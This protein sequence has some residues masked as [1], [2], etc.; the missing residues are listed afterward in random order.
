M[1]ISVTCHPYANRISAK[2]PVTCHPYLS[3]VLATYQPYVS[4]MPERLKILKT[5][6]NSITSIIIPS[7]DCNFVLVI[8]ILPKFS[9]CDLTPL[10]LLPIFSIIYWSERRCAGGALQQGYAVAS[11]FIGIFSSF[12]LSSLLSA[13]LLLLICP[14]RQQVS[15]DSCYTNVYRHSHQIWP[16]KGLGLRVSHRKW[17]CLPHSDCM[18]ICPHIASV[19]KS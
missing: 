18:A 11:K 17:E 15:V 5:I 1:L 3:N 8:S 6:V 14:A 10:P 16:V 13:L 2:R 9:I 4:S 7:Q 19:G 12:S